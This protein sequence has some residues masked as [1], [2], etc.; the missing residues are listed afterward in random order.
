MNKSNSWVNGITWSDMAAHGSILDN[1]SKNTLHPRIVVPHLLLIIILYSIRSTCWV[2]KLFSMLRYGYELEE[3]TSQRFLDRI[4]HSKAIVGWLIEGSER[5]SSWRAIMNHI[6]RWCQKQD[7]VLQMST[8]VWHLTYHYQIQWCMEHRKQD[9]WVMYC[10]GSN[11][12][13]RRMNAS[14]G[15]DSS[16]CQIVLGKWSASMLLVE[17]DVCEELARLMV[18][19]SSPGSCCQDC[20]I[21]YKCPWE[22]ETRLAYY[23]SHHK[24]LISS[25]LFF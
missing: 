10:W 2:Y 23:L 13:Q 4:W 16:S 20:F 14:N 5:I 11:F 24:G 6:W 21:T 8:K 17:L 9:L 25:F 1:L 22:S 12:A 19:L 15:M 7:A 3:K 18:L